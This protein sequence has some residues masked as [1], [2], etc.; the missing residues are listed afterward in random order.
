MLSRLSTNTNKYCINCAN[1]IEPIIHRNVVNYDESNKFGKCKKMALTNTKTFESAFVARNDN[2]KCGY[3]G[4]Y[5][6]YEIKY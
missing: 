1:Y 2:N 3:N 4:K 6:E 5:Y